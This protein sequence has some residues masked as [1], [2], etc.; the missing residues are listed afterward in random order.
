MLVAGPNGQGVDLDAGSMCAQIVAP[1]PAGRAHRHRQPVGQLRLELHELR[2][3]LRRRRQPGRLRRQRRRRRRRRLPRVLRRRSRDDGRPGLRRGHR[4]RPRRSSSGCAAVVRTHAGRARQG[5]RRPAIGARAAASHTGI[6]GHRRPGVRRRVPPGRRRAGRDHRG[7]VRGR[8]H[9]RHPAAAA[10][11]ARRRRVDRRRLGRRHRRRHRPRTRPRAA[12][13]ARRPARPRSTRAAAP[14]EP[15]QPDR[16]GRRRDQGHHPDRARDRR[17][18]PRRRRR[19]VPR[20]GHPGQPGPHGTRG[21]VLPRPRPRADRRLPRAP[22]PALHRRR[23]PSCPTSLGKP[24]LT[25]TELAIADPANPA[26]AGCRDAGVLCYAS[27]NRAVTA[28]VAPL[29]LRPLA[30]APRPAEACDRRA[31]ARRRSCARSSRRRGGRGRRAPP[32]GSARGGRGRRRRRRR[33]ARRRRSR[34]CCRPGGCPACSPRRSPTGGCVAALDELLA[35][36]PGTACLTVASGRPPVYSHAPDTSLVAGVAREAAHRGRRP[37]GARPRPPVPHAVVAGRGARRGV[38]AGDLWLVGGGDPLLATA[39]YPPA[40]ATSRRSARRS[41]RWPTPRATPASRAI[42]ARLV[43]DESPLRRRPLPRPRGPTRFIDQDQIGPLSRPHRERRLGRRSR[44]TPT[45]ASP[46]RSRPR[47]R[48]PTRRT[49]LDGRSSPRA[50]SRSTAARR[51]H[52]AARGAVEVPA[53]ESPPLQR[54]RRARCCARAT[55]RPAELLLKE[56][57][58]RPRAGRRRRPTA[59]RSRSSVAGGSACP[60]RVVVADGSGLADGNRLTCALVQAILDRDRA[61]RPTI[62]AALPVAG[63]DRHADRRFLDTPVDGAAAGQDRHAQPGDGARR[64][65]RHDA[66]RAALLRASSSTSPRERRRRRGRPRP[67]GR[68]RRHPRRYPEG[69]R[70]PTSARV[71]RRRASAGG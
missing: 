43:G 32:A 52:G 29:A 3:P 6:A 67:P 42:A 56:L 57:G 61:R 50:A 66:G 28:L 8:R 25:A 65:P 45:S 48:P 27:A 12:A 55:T 7:G 70:S 51:G 46:T 10:G 54:G 21:A 31:A 17:S 33:S 35:R 62:A 58:R 9:L 5:R 16:H 69:R 26:V 13:A 24:I 11:P 4:R 22:G 49:V 38:V 53:V 68:A 64:L 19:R 37:R 1:V 34:R 40:S 2:P 23:R 15:Q 30:P 44:R 47:T 71:R 41:R 18:P 20:H 60:R 63:R 36:Q 39:A 14:V 59:P